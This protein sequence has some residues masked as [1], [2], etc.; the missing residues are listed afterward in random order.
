MGDE[1]RVYLFFLRPLSLQREFFYSLA[2]DV[3]YE[4]GIRWTYLC[5]LWILFESGT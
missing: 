4:Y 2:V 3:P 1:V 5:F